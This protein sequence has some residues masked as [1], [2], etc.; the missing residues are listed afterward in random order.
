MLFT[1]GP[2]ASD[3]TQHW[4]GIYRASSSEVGVSCGMLIKCQLVSSAVRWL[5]LV[6]VVVCGGGDVEKVVIHRYLQCGLWGVLLR[7]R[8]ERLDNDLL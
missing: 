6:V 3:R 2:A 7:E 8:G 5:V 4:L 1:L